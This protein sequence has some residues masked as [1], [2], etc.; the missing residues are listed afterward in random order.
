MSGLSMF[1][2]LSKVDVE[3]RL[4]YGVATAEQ[5]DRS[6]ETCDYAASKPNFE[7]WSAD[8]HA[9]SG[10]LSK[11]NLRAMHGKVAAGKL[12]EIHFNDAA[13]QIEICAKVVDDDE[14]KKVVE[15]VY[16]GFSQGGSY[17][18]RWTDVAGVKRYE[19][20][21]SEIS[22]VDLPCLA[23]ATF[24]MVKGDGLA[25]RHHFAPAV[26][27]P[28][29]DNAA[30]AAKA[31]E[32]AKTAGQEDFAPFL[33]EARS[34]MLKAV[35]PPPSAETATEGKPADPAEPVV[36]AADP[37]PAVDDLA[38]GW[39]CKADGSFHA[40]KAEARRHGATLDAAASA[41]AEAGPA[42]DALADLGKTL[43]AVPAVPVARLVKAEG[44]DALAK[45]LGQ[46][47]RL[48]DLIQS[49]AWL[50]SRIQAET[51]REGDGSTMAN[52]IKEAVT[53]LGALL[54]EMATEELGELFTAPNGVNPDYYYNAAGL[55]PEGHL[56]AL[57]KFAESV[58]AL[59][60]SEALA[61]MGARNSK[62]DSAKIQAM[63]DHACDLGASCKDAN[64]AA[65]ADDLQKRADTLTAERDDA[66]AKH[67]ALKDIVDTFPVKL[68][69]IHKM[70]A[71]QPMPA[72]LV[73]RAV[74]KVQDAG[75]T[76]PA[77]GISEDELAKAL[78]AMTPEERAL[79]MTKV[80]LGQP[81]RLVGAPK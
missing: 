63:H 70:I 34:E 20:K 65:G 41:R 10:G 37:T 45:D 24:E 3:K 75:G 15:G 31:A 59:A 33:D 80:S 47:S 17:G 2:P 25:E 71:A 52:R 69:A 73:G 16:T 40:T 13:K 51:V 30:V 60:K 72:H 27:V 23:S 29:P 44:E 35:L 61:K 46:V 68:D 55:L 18:K 8:V 64:K 76:D 53:T 50:Q 57:V 19:A 66:M 43:G 28:D 67:A 9:A 78:A 5:P 7:K 58:P 14:W 36:K 74:S 4:V 79:V 42:L 49:L 39:L 62:K 81:H 32:M 56:D 11:G 38:Q 6:S 22:L 26:T 21:P 12:E 54:P 77:D 1:I 48:A